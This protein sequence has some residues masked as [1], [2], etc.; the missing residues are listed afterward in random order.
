MDHLAG[1][2]VA[3]AHI[4]RLVAAQHPGNGAGWDTALGA[5]RVLAAALGAAL[6]NDR[7]LDLGRVLVGLVCGRE[8]R[9]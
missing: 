1:D 7:A 9:S 5:E 8:D 4:G 3:L 6:G 2:R